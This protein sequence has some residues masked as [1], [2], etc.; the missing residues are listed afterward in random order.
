MQA[1]IRILLRYRNVVLL[2][3]IAGLAAG[4]SQSG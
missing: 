4:I 3:F 2:I 1:L